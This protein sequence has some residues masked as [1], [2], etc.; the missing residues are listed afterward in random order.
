[1]PVFLSDQ[2]VTGFYEGF[3]NSVLWPLFHGFV[4]RSAYSTADYAAYVRVNQRFA[5]VIAERAGSDDHVWI[6]DYQLCLVPDL[7]RERGV[8]CP[9]GFFLHVPFPS[10][11]TY[12]TLPVREELLK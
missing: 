2:E 3:S 10:S 9:I 4:N 6:H 5:D 8:T 7:L 1:H 11:E 12:R